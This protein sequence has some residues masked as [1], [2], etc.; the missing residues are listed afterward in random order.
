MP[1]RR[2]V[3]PLHTKEL[4]IARQDFIRPRDNFE[5]IETI[6]SYRIT[7]R[8]V[9]ALLR[10]T[11]G[12]GN[13]HVSERNDMFIMSL[14]RP[15]SAEEKFEFD[16]SR[17]FGRSGSSSDAESDTQTWKLETSPLSSPFDLEPPGSDTATGWN[18]NSRSE[19][20]FANAAASVARKRESSIPLIR[21]ST[22][23]TFELPPE[24]NVEDRNL[25]YSFSDVHVRRQGVYN[26]HVDRRGVASSLY[27][28]N[29]SKGFTSKVFEV[30]ARW[31]WVQTEASHSDE[32][33]GL[34]VAVKRLSLHTERGQFLQEYNALK[35]ATKDHHR[36]IVQLLNAFRYEEHGNAVYYNF[37]FPLAAGNLKE[38]FNHHVAPFAFF[39]NPWAHKPTGEVDLNTNLTA[40]RLS[41]EFYSLAVE[42]LWSEFEGLGSAL[43]H[44]HEKCQIA[45][46]D[47]KPSNVLLYGP[48]GSPPKITAKLTDFGL[49]VDLTTRLTWQLG[50]KAAQSAWQYDAPEIRAAFNMSRNS[51]SHAKPTEVAHE[52]NAEQLM[53]GDVWKL[54]SVFVEMLTF[55]V[56]GL[57]S[58]IRFRKFI[59]TTVGELTSDDLSDTQFDDGEKV[60]VEV[61]QWLLR[62]AAKDLRAQEM[63]DLLRSMLD[64]GHSR[65]SSR[66]IADMLRG[67]SFCN[68]SDGERILNFTTSE[69]VSCPSLLDRCKD[70]VEKR[71]GHQVSWR[72][73]KDGTR[74]CPQGYSRISWYWSSTKLYID[75]PTTQ[76]EA[77]KSRCQ[78]ISNITEPVSHP[79]QSGYPGSSPSGQQVDS[80]SI[81]I[82]TGS[83]VGG[84]PWPSLTSGSQSQNAR[85]S[86]YN[87]GPVN[88]SHLSVQ[89]E[90]KE[91]YWCIDRAWSEPRSTKLC[92]LRENPDIC[93]DESLYESL[94]KEYN[95]VRAWKGR[96]LSW[97]SCLGIEFIKFVRTS[98]SHNDV[99]RVQIGLPPSSSR[100][101]ELLR[102][103]PEEVHMKIAASELIAGI[104]QPEGGRGKTTTL[105]MIPKR[106]MTQSAHSTSP[107]DWGMHALPRLSLWKILAWIAFLAI[108]GL[109]F[110]IYWLVFINKTDLQNAFIPFTFLATMVLI[111]LGVPQLLEVD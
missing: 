41:D 6:S 89:A 63:H 95:R 51:S 62:L 78:P 55:L 91:I 15:L 57:H 61:L 110:V 49:A 88:T 19:T 76:A 70:L 5:H 34:K 86:L 26:V 94:I 1:V 69:F 102:L 98:T 12:E 66:R 90:Y 21:G 100:S 38:L 87:N 25:I 80:N 71:V 65:P 92:S 44:L 16:D 40:H 111:G 60:K 18:T 9:V 35:A 28:I 58:T 48:H 52:L 20:P 85:N 99:I 79:S 31:S 81:A 27:G 64:Q 93:D 30:D 109:T 13:F 56:E 45:H 2:R 23:T 29:I 75:V 68:Y 36:N 4:A 7:R 74:W 53:S 82:P 8:D 101:Y 106:I 11:F 77:Y 10:R 22:Q 108:L 17:S 104:Y 54:G 50:S 103:T 24:D 73:F 47:I 37:S 32:P 3:R 84:Y 46:S 72:P 97:K 59:T 14:P 107:D 67:F 43:A 33:R 96:L 39:R 105:N 42:N 83:S